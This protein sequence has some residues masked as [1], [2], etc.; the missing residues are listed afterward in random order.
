MHI[1]ST[2]AQMAMGRT[3][4]NGGIGSIVNQHAQEEKKSDNNDDPSGRDPVA[5]R[6]IS[7]MCAK[8]GRYCEIICKNNPAEG[9]P[10]CK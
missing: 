10:L 3:V 6:R 8:K 4:A 7:D 2:I 1:S 5:N 9:G